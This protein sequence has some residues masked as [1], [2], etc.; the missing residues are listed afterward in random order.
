[1]C[2]LSFRISSSL[3]TAL[4]QLINHFL[5]NP[6]CFRGK[7]FDGRDNVETEEEGGQFFGG[8]YHIHRTTTAEMRR[9]LLILFFCRF[10]FLSPFFERL[11]HTPS[12]LPEIL[13]ATNLPAAEGT[14]VVTT[15][16]VE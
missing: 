14:S 6:L 10:V 1:L 13:G 11:P 2:G 5:A 3:I 12:A 8:E 16:G 4:F 15:A 9:Q 7:R